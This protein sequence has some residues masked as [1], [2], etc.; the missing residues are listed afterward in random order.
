VIYL[1]LFY[2]NKPVLT[3]YRERRPPE[4]DPLAVVQAK[5]L[6][7][8][9]S[10]KK[11]LE[12][13][14]EDFFVLMGNFD[15]VSFKGG[16]ADRYVVCWFDDKENDFIQAARRMGGVK[17]PPGMLSKVDE[18]GKKTYNTSFTADYGKLE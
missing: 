5:K 12:G 3:I 11:C 8:T 15:Y 6:S 10:E 9:S 17:F 7:V 14:I 4:R 18:R 2:W 16:E 1:A 13:N